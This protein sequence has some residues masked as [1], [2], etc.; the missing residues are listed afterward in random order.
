MVKK[1]MI[2]AF[3]K[4]KLVFILIFCGILLPIIVYGQTESTRIIKGKV[5]WSLNEVAAGCNIIIKDTPDGTISDLNG[6]FSIEVPTN[7]EVILVVSCI[8]EPVEVKIKENVDFYRIS[9]ERKIRSTNYFG[10]STG[11]FKL[12]YESAENLSPSFGINYSFQTNIF[13]KLYLIPEIHLLIYPNDFN[14]SI[15]SAIE[16]PIRLKY[17]F[18]GRLSILGGLG[19]GYSFNK[20]SNDFYTLGNFGLLY[21]SFRRY[22]LSL[23]Y[24]RSLSSYGM[25]EIMIENVLI[26]LKYRI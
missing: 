25:D 4:S 12:S 18:I 13:S 11:L 8:C 3:M 19:I 9:L 23:N 10:V 21:D 14:N 16:L 1:N 5:Y 24:G 2:R 7:K 22:S 17:R 26:I 15:F 6:E 20:D